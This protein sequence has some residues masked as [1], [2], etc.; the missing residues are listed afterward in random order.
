MG[1]DL[2]FY[3]AVISSVLVPLAG[4][5]RWNHPSWRPYKLLMLNFA[6]AAFTE[7]VVTVMAFMNEHNVHVINLFFIV[8]FSILS[9]YLLSS[10]HFSRRSE[11]IFYTWAVLILVVSI[12]YFFMYFNR[13]H[14]NVVPVTLQNMLLILL[15]A[16]SIWQMMKGDDD[17][18]RHPK[19]WFLTALLFHYSVG[20][21]LL[22]TSEIFAYKNFP[23]HYYS[24]F[25]YAIVNIITNL[26][27]IYA[28]KWIRA[29]RYSMQ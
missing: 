22:A 10:G 3:L 28:F 23:M 19:F 24:W 26:L 18:F 6:V 25:L 13:D 1:A 5:W 9:R 21:C 2:L 12:V 15:S 11:T 8:Q 14:Y 27:F 7:I 20:F 16:M 17:L 4:T 29:P